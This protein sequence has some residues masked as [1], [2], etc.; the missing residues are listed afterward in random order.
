M[1]PQFK[2]YIEEGLWSK[3][4][5]RS[6]NKNM[7]KEDIQDCINFFNYEKN[8]DA[9]FI[10]YDTYGLE[11][12]HRE[13]RKFVKKKLNT[14]LKRYIMTNGVLDIWENANLPSFDFPFPNK[15]EGYQVNVNFNGSDNKI[16]VTSEKGG[17]VLDITDTKYGQ[18]I[19]EVIH[20]IPMDI[21][22][23]NCEKYIKLT[24]EKNWDSFSKLLYDD[25][26]KEYKRI[27]TNCINSGKEISPMNDMYPN[28][29]SK[30]LQKYLFGG[31]QYNKNSK[32][33]T[34]Y[35]YNSQYLTD[36]KLTEE[37]YEI[38]K[39]AYDDAK[40]DLT[41]VSEGLWSKGVDRSKTGETR[42]GD[43]DHDK[44]IVDEFII[45]VY[46]Y[47]EKEDDDL[48]LWHNFL[49]YIKFDEC[50]YGEYSED[51]GPSDIL[52]KYKSFGD[53]IKRCEEW[54]KWQRHNFGS[55]FDYKY[56]EDILN[57]F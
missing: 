57:M 25:L 4:V 7:R 43:I 14:S 48:D 16:T 45:A 33:W 18:K 11:R 46:E 29:S 2:E 6:K 3:G 32:D 13:L 56:F 34:V 23:E 51:W 17:N 37:I 1:I 5:D 19:I 31:L 36:K 24:I 52:D 50:D 15:I 26:Y 12:T 39:H 42:L 21:I 47:S 40:R 27:I 10:F 55:Q 54:I 41:K 22:N 53:F 8:N 30:E 35:F 38:Y 44:K 20:A 28:V 49:R 9:F